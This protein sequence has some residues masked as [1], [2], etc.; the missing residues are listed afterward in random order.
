MSLV[1]GRIPWLVPLGNSVVYCKDSQESMCLITKRH[2]RHYISED[3][4]S[5]R[6]PHNHLQDGFR[7][8]FYYLVCQTHEQPRSSRMLAALPCGFLDLSLSLCWLH[9]RLARSI[10]CIDR[11]VLCLSSFFFP[12][13]S[14]R[15]SAGVNCPKDS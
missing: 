1:C 12:G 14:E 10:M 11:G 3:A 5:P 4:S 13:S 15:E 9:P 2:S 8:E 7:G 6:W